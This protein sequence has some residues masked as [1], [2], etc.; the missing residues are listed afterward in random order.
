MKI[1]K[2]AAW[3]ILVLVGVYLI[4]P[5]PSA[6][7]FTRQNYQHALLPLE[8]S[9]PELEKFIAQK[10]A[11]HKLKLDNEARIIWQNDSLKNQAEYSIVYL[12][13]FGASQEEGDPVHSDIAKKFG[14]NL[15]LSRLAE[16]GIDTVRHDPF[17]GRQIL[18]VCN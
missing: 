9:G 7:A 3:I 2:V 15:Y 17:H 18:G 10:E 11:L 4:G 1:L 13:G 5:R 14:C 16:H 8:M 12:H 6:P